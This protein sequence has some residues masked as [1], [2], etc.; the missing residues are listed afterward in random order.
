MPCLLCLLKGSWLHLA[1]SETLVTVYLGR[2]GWQMPL[3][4]KSLK[5][6]ESNG[7]MNGGITS[8]LV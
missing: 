6:D 1:L 8:V 3:S 2:F 4:V 7:T 5:E